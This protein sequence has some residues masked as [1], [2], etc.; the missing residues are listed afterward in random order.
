MT[1]EQ[2]STII[3]LLH[4]LKWAA[5]VTLFLIGFIVGWLVMFVHHT[6]L[7]PKDSP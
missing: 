6:K 5:F 2:A 7:Q 4:G 1:P 3:E